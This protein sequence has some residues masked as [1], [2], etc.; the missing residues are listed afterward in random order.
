MKKIII[1]FITL[2]V[3][4][5]NTIPVQAVSDFYSENNIQFYDPNAC[6]P[7]SGTSASISDQSTP[8]GN[9]KWSI[10]PGVPTNITEDFKAFMDKVAQYTSYEPVIT[11]TT[12]GTH[13]AGSDHYSGNAGD[14]GSVGNSFGTNAAQPGVKNEK[15]DE[16]A[17][18]GLIAAGMNKS[19]AKQKALNG[20]VPGPDNINTSI[21]GVRYRVQ[22]IWKAADH[23]D[24]VHI[25]IKKIGSAYYE[26]KNNNFL[27]K[28][29][30]AF[31]SL[32]PFT[33]VSAISEQENHQG[34]E[35][36]VYIVGDSIIKRAQNEITLKL[37][38][39][40]YDDV[41]INADEGRAINEDT[42]GYG[43]SGLEAVDKDKAHIKNSNVAIIALG[44]NDK[45]LNIYLRKII[46]NIKSYNENIKIYWINI[47]SGEGINEKNEYIKNNSN[48]G[49][50]VI[51]VKSANIP[52]DSDGI[53]QKTPEGSEIIASTITSVVKVNEAGR[54]SDNIDTGGCCPAPEGNS[55]GGTQVTGEGNAEKIWNFLT[56]SRMGF[57]NIQA[58]GVLGNFARESGGGEYKK[59]DPKALN[60]SSGAFGIAQWLDRKSALKSFAGTDY[61]KL[62]KQLDFIEYEIFGEDGKAKGGKGSEYGAYEKFK[63]TKNI[64]DATYM[65]A[66]YYE[67]P[68]PGEENN[69]IRHSQAKT[70]YE[71]FSDSTISSGTTQTNNS[72]QSTCVCN[73]PSS[74]GGGLTI[75]NPKNLKDFISAYADFAREAG[76]KNGVPYDFILAQIAHESGLPLSLLASKYNNFGGIK[77]TGKPGEKATPPMRTYEENQGYIMARFRAF[78]SPI[79]GLDQQAQFFKDNERY[80]TA[81]NYP[82]NPF[83]FAEEVAKAGYATDSAYAQKVKSMIKNVQE[84]LKKQGKP[85][86]SELETTAD[87]GSS[88]NCVGS[89]GNGIV[90]DGFSFP[91]GELKKSQVGTNDGMPCNNSGGCHHDST[92][93]FDIGKA[94]SGS[95]NILGS[96]SE[97]LPVY[98]IEDG[99]IV[100][101][102][103]SYD[104]VEGC[105]S[106][107]LKGASGWV[108]WYGHTKNETIKVGSKV[109]A[110][111]KI[112][113]IGPS[114]CAKGSEPHLHIDRGTPKGHYGGS[115]SSR[116]SSIN[117]V[118]NKLWEGLP[119]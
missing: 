35:G 23:Y 86:S 4:F 85:I 11:T 113:E 19:K 109:K 74:S 9:G 115:P 114:K 112:A 57:T 72:T 17:A 62:E 25:G 22:V 94:K 78:D 39:S 6:D 2:M 76:Q 118:I 31:K 34:S 1:S 65:W 80:R 47:F 95:S 88:S 81:L 67:R 21:N 28:F 18:A 45:K 27:N 117:E 37:N 68:E 56:S 69:S 38:E 87:G 105:P 20:V 96:G 49:Y 99:E 79:E 32:L 30:S 5:F 110:G 98:A 116:D 40:R 60:P 50:E 111:E 54:S 52:L 46:K 58:A 75:S 63:K 93:A 16:I 91:V 26:N 15:G 73:D 82:N 97:G 53:H 13:A 66:K 8:T 64:R 61:E 14:F 84:E 55:E 102:R 77:Y 41:Y 10:Q 89:S 71:E 48:L 59:I 101:L 24:H 103:S 7:N 92:P 42:V 29:S 70:A 36:S 51:D 119:N 106:Y 3:V 43:D 100:Q 104:G 83:K 33:N 44:T 107:Q 90:V 12:N 108:Y